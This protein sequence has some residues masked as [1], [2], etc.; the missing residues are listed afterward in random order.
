[1]ALQA[2]QDSYKELE[3][4]VD[5]AEART[6]MAEDLL[7]QEHD[8]LKKKLE[9]GEDA[10]VDA[11]MYRVWSYNPNLDLSFLE[12][13][14]QAILSRWRARLDEELWTCTKAAAKDE[15]GDKAS[16]RPVGLSGEPQNDAIL[17]PLTPITLNP[18]SAS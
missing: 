5:T 16:S 11:T 14:Q 13:E 18:P 2:L 6:K 17:D 9:D 8:G 4:R 1:M 12:G 10:L 15:L 3:S 7:A